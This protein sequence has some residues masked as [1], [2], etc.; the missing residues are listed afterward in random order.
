MRAMSLRTV[1]PGLLAACVPGIEG[2]SDSSPPADTGELVEDGPLVGTLEEGPEVVCDVPTDGFDRL[3]EE[4]A[5]RG[6]TG[7]VADPFEAWAAWVDGRGGNPVAQDLDGDGDLDLL[8]TQPAD[9]PFVYAN[10]GT[11]HF[12]LVEGA[13]DLAPPGDGPWALTAAAVDL[14]GDRLPE[15]VIGGGGGFAV[16]TNQGGLRWGAPVPVDL[17]EVPSGLV[18]PG[19]SLGDADGDGDLDLAASASGRVVAGRVDKTD[20]GALMDRLSLQT[21]SGWAPTVPLSRGGLGWSTQVLQFTDRDGDGDQDLLIPG[22]IGGATAFWRNDGTVR[23]VPWFVDDAPDIGADI[24]MSG[25][26]IAS[27]DLNGDG[28]LDYCITDLGPIRCLTSA[29]GAAGELYAEG[30]RALGLAPTTW[31]DPDFGTTGWSLDLADLDN[32]GLLDAVQSSAPEIDRAPLTPD[33]LPDLV[34]QGQAD[35]T[36]LDRSA[37]VGFSDNAWHHGLVTADFDGDGALDVVVTGPG[38]APLYWANRCTS[39]SWLV[40][41]LE[42]PPGNTDGMGARVEV[43]AG[44]RTHLREVAATRGPAQGPSLVHVGLG[45]A[46]TVDALRVVFPDGAR[47]EAEGVGTRRTVTAIHPDAPAR[48]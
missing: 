28:A 16:H 30:G 20:P 42:G 4:G 47:V 18:F 7:V 46:E 3:V 13:V 15:L 9:D 23:G 29:G 12:T 41:E 34:F 44:G 11:G 39:G 5:A 19:L 32:D 33:G 37:E 17:G 31:A 8:V 24:G 10:D 48:Q 22:D 36:F 40:I 26:G 6:L 1:L 38:Q 45:A 43:T 14:D 35:G 27:A 2:K 25:M 21:D